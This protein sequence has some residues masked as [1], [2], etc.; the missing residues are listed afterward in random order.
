VLERISD[1]TYQRLAWFHRSQ[2]VSS[3]DE[4]I[5]QLLD[6]FSFERFIEGE[7]T[8]FSHAQKA[9]ARRFHALL[10]TFCEGTPLMLDPR[11]IIDDPRW[12]EIRNEAKELLRV[13]ISMRTRDHRER[14]M[15]NKREVDAFLA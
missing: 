6:D 8:G 12:A 1:E 14:A 5:N 7:E 9:A 15:P 13:A 3:P 2:E 4:L 11:K 10:M